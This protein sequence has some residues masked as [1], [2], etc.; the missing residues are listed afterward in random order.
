[1]PAGARRRAQDPDAAGRSAG[2]LPP[3]D[4]EPGREAVVMP[5]DRRAEALLRAERLAD[6]QEAV[7]RLRSA[8]YAAFRSQL[9][10]RRFRRSAPDGGAGGGT[11]RR[12][13]WPQSDPC[14]VSGQP[15]ERQPLQPL[16]APLAESGVYRRQRGGGF[17]A[18]RRGSALVAEAGDAEAAGQGARRGVGGLHR[19]DAAEAGGAEAG[20]PA[21]SGAQAERR[22]ASG[23]RTV[24]D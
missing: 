21:V 23:V 22:A 18:Q 15:G 6:R 1:M 5:S 17:P 19:R 2:G 14:A 9:G 13:R 11:R 3:I 24:R 4:A 8:V 12:F 16:V 10:H 20:V 7:G